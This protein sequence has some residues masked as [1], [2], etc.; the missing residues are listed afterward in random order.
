M[1]LAT[2]CRL[3]VKH[4][5]E[6]GSNDPTQ[7]RHYNRTRIT[8]TR[9]DDMKVQADVVRGVYNWWLAVIGLFVAI[10]IN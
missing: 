9:E 6:I 5:T 10:Y 4:A 7:R 2:L 3:S 1:T 8:L